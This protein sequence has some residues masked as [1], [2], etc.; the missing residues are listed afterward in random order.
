MPRFMMSVMAVAVVE[1][2]EEKQD[3][4]QGN[5]EELTETIPISRGKVP[6][7]LSKGG[8]WLGGHKWMRGRN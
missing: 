3:L 1:G 7:Q 2:S 6:S 4:Y 5:S 8:G